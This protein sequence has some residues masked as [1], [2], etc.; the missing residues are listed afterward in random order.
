MELKGKYTSSLRRDWNAIR[1][2]P[3]AVFSAPLSQL[4][5]S[6]LADWSS[7][8]LSPDGRAS[9]PLHDVPLHLHWSSNLSA[10]ALAVFRSCPYPLPHHDSK[11]HEERIWPSLGQVLS[12]SNLPYPNGQSY[13]TE[14]GLSRTHPLRQSRQILKRGVHWYFSTPTP[15]HFTGRVCKMLVYMRRSWRWISS[16]LS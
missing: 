2:R 7:L 9:P 6:F 14:F 12:Q 11:V 13:T 8:P 10:H 4:H 5:S 3:P 15:A 16:F 1:P